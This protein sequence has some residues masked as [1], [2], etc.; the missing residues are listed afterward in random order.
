MRDRGTILT[1]SAVI[2]GLALSVG[3]SWLRYRH[4]SAVISAHLAVNSQMW[5]ASLERELE[6]SFEVL[7]ATRAFGEAT[8]SLER[9]DFRRFVAPGLERHPEIRALEWVPRVP[10]GERESV[11]DAARRA[12]YEPGS[13]SWPGSVKDAPRKRGLRRTAASTVFASLLHVGH[14]PLPPVTLS[15][16]P[17]RSGWLCL[18]V[19]CAGQTRDFSIRQLQ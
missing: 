4:E 13:S 8:A 17:D 7:R 9:D 3:V 16:R 11:E 12:R 14:G 10:A 18:T 15:L 2:A 5:A 19:T 1:V 6:L